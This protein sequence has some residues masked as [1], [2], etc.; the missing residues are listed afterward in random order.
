MNHSVRNVQE[1]YDTAL[2]LYNDDVVGGEASADSIL[3]DL[4]KGIDNL[5]ENW[6]GTDA[7]VRI[8]EVVRVHNAMVAVRNA[9]VQLAVDSSIV[10]SKYRDI[11]M[12]NGARMD[13]LSPLDLDTKATLPDYSDNADTIY[14]T[15]A[16]ALGKSYIDNANQ[17][18]ANF[19]NA[20]KTKY[21]ELMDNWTRG[22]GRDVARD[23]FESFIQN[24]NRY[25]ETLEEVSENVAQAL[26]NYE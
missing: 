14:I 24:V 4:V 18:I 21:N 13:Q 7:G 22:T 12:A 23:A 10:A 17:N 3:R 25:R 11:Q 15:D 19:E 6:R 9:L 20:V 8:E 1:L 5:K 26:Q 2:T 16:A